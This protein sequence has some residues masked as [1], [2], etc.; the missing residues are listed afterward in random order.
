MMKKTKAADLGQ[1]IAAANEVKLAHYATL[2]KRFAGNDT[3]MQRA[4]L[5]AALQHAPVTTYDA[6]KYLDI[7]DVP[8][9]C[10]ELRA[11][12][13]HIVTFRVSQQ[14]DAGVIHRRIGLYVLKSEGVLND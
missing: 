14:T 6:R 12:G 9:R 11:C 5:A 13:L 2:L 4:R 3:R 8:A 10:T 7:Y 1:G